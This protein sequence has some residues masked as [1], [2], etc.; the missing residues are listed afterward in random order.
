MKTS[1]FR[2]LILSCFPAFLIPLTSKGSSA[3]WAHRKGESLSWDNAGN[4]APATVPNGPTD[5]ATFA[6]SSAAT[7]GTYDNIELDSI[8]FTQ[9]ANAITINRQPALSGDTLTFSGSGVVNNSTNVEAFIANINQPGMAGTIVFQND[10]SAGNN[11]SYRA[12]GTVS[13]PAVG[14]AIRFND[15]STAGSATITLDGGNNVRGDPLYKVGATLYFSDSANAGTAQV[16]VNSGATDYSYG[17]TVFF[18]DDSDAR[19]S[20]LTVN[21]GTQATSGGGKVYFSDRA[22]AGTAT[23]TLNGGKGSGASGSLLD[24]SGLATAG[25]ATLIAYG[26][27]NGGDG[28]FINVDGGGNFGSSRLEIFGNAVLY[29]SGHEGTSAT[30]GSIEGDGLIVLHKRGVTVGATDVDT[31][32]SGVIK[33]P[34]AL[35]KTGA[36]VLSLSGANPYRGATT[37]DAGALLVNAPTGSGTGFGRVTVAGG[38]LGGNGHIAGSVIISAGLQPGFSAPEPVGLTIGESHFL[39]HWHVQ[40]RSRHS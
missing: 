4:W 29:V 40:L 9:E 35:T 10:A 28:A 23:F 18:T 6:Q 34:G 3:T 17:G 20:N 2:L 26:G 31:T 5:I 22:T 33:G 39:S 8:V 12:L 37:I 7:V 32:F 36:G 25:E 21:G 14:G 24:F 15:S 13:H 27:T 16:R 11:T 30:F 38:T 1:Q 19:Q